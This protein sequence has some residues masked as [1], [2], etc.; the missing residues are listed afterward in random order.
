MLKPI[1]IF[2]ACI[3]LSTAM[4]VSASSSI[5]VAFE[6]FELSMNDFEKYAGEIG[7][8]LNDSYQLR[9]TFMD[10]KLSERH[11][12]SAEAVAIDGPNV[13]GVFRGY[14]VNLDKYFTKHWYFSLNLGHY[15][16]IYRHQILTDQR[17]KNNTFTVG[18]GVG[19]FKNNPFGIRNAYV[20]FNVPLRYYFDSIEETMLGDTRVREHS[21]VNNFWLFIG[22]HL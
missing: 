13:E 1:K 20:N 19:F 4:N 10:I 17:L 12:S 18:T 2:F 21:V 5:F 16:D 3:T 15:T 14:E 8:R 9:L 6:L 22:F 7:Y 11:L